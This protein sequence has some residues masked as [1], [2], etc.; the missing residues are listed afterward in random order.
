[1]LT[2]HHIILALLCALILSSVTFR[3][4]PILVVVLMAGTGIGVIIPDIHMKKPKKT[5]LKTFAW[6]LVQIGRQICAPAMCGIYRVFSGLSIEPGDKRLTHSIPGIVLLFAII[7]VIIAI[8]VF[9][10]RNII[11]GFLAEVFLGGILLGLCLHLT[12]DICTRKGISVFF[13]FNGTMISGSIRPCDFYDTRIFRFQL[14][15]SYILGL[16][17]LLDFAEPSIAFLA[18]CGI[19]GFCIGVASM[20]WQSDV[21]IRFPENR[22]SDTREVQPA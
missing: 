6:Y 17:V 12:E 9:F 15:H 21:K 1:M 4:D 2:R 20:V 11:P 16:I 7:S 14:Q 22:F 5:R 13:P 18:I 19:M 3:F 10:F 8:P